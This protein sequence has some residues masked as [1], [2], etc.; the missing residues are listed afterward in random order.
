MALCLHASV[1]AQAPKPS[2]PNKQKNVVY[3]NQV[4]KNVI[5]LIGDGMGFAQTSLARLSLG[6]KGAL[7]MDSMP[8]AAFVKTYS[9]GPGMITDSAAAATAL[10][11]GNKTINGMIALM[12]DGTP[13]KTIL[14]AA[15]EAGKATGLITTVTITHATPAGFGA[16]ER[17]RNNER[18]IAPQYLRQKI[19]VLLGGGEKF[20]LPKSTPGSERLDTR[21]L[22][23]EAG[24]AGYAVVRTREELVSAKQ[25]KLLGLFAK[26]YMEFKTS[27]PS[28]AEMA[29]KALE[30]LEKKGTGFFLMIEGGQ[31]DTACHANDT[32]KALQQTL[33]FDEAVKT[34]LAFARKNGNTLVL[35]TAD[36]ETGGMAIVKAPKGSGLDYQTVWGTQG[37]SATV[38]PLLADG[39][40]ASE[41]GG[42]M[43]NTEIPR[44]IAKLWKLKL[45]D[46][47]TNETI[48]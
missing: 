28:V 14:E 24:A 47:K 45:S 36:H 29:S 31:I 25:S 10:A 7:A 32:K 39:P 41:F 46:V 34:A 20:F 42:V 15:A 17:E 9:A 35:V 8:Q 1:L 44:K 21:D 5:L 33:D 43:D 27:E 30:V 2:H 26:G 37:H 11:T 22:I 16:H 40:G 38:V 48:K 18:D 3:L 19:D 6:P 12:P 13:A 23:T 4:P